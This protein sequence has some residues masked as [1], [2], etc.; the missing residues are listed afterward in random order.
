MCKVIQFTGLSGAGKTTIATTLAKQLSEENIKVLIVDGDEFRKKYAADL[1]FSNADRLENIN[2][3]ANFV[4]VN[5]ANYDL[6]I[7]SAINPFNETRAIFTEQCEAQLIYIK[8]DLDT[9]IKRDTKGLYR[10]AMLPSNHPEHL[11]NLTGVNQHFDEPV[12]YT[13]TIDTT[14]VSIQQAVDEIKANVFT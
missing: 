6:V 3:M 13:F 12:T 5:K 4:N 2:R 14:K 1:G 11:P 10:R 7:I 8:C 9:L